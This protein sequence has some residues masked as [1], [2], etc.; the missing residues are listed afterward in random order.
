MKG[1][2]NEDPDPIP[3]TVRHAYRLDWQVPMV[4]KTLSWLVTAQGG[5]AMGCVATGFLIRAT[6]RRVP[7]PVEMKR[8]RW[9]TATVLSRPWS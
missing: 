8:R 1:D 7:L 3:A 5:F 4:G 6:G 2:A 9:W